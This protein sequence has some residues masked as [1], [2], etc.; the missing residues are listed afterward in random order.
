MADFTAAPVLNGSE[1]ES[2]ILPTEVFG[3]AFSNQDALS[4]VF[5]AV[6]LALLVCPWPRRRMRRAPHEFRSSPGQR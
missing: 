4:L 6:T 3:I 1:G 5:F 2:V